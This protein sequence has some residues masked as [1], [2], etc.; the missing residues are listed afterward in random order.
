MLTVK[1]SNG[2]TVKAKEFSYVVQVWN[3]GKWHNEAVYSPERQ[4][5][6]FDLWDEIVKCGQEARVIQ[7][8]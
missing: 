1:L 6:A 8:V 5:A 2:R 4:N 3:A 7:F